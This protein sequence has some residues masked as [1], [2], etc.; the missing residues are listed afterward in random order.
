[1]IIAY[2]ESH[3]ASRVTDIAKGVPACRDV[4]RARLANL[5]AEGLI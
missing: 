1:M 5:E 3:G 2:L 4:V